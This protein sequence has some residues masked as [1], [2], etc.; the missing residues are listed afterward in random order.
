MRS[1]VSL[2][3]LRHEVRDRVDGKSG[4]LENENHRHCGTF[5]RTCIRKAPPRKGGAG[6]AGERGR[7]G[8]YYDTPWDLPEDPPIE[9]SS[10]ISG[11]G[12]AIRQ[13]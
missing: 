5:P 2:C 8:I 3:N 10:S 13:R 12:S 4:D 7:G 6:R 1:R 11:C 9:P